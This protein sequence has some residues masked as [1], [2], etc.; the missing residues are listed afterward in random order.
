MSREY[1][2]RPIAG[3]AAVV[4]RDDM[5]LLTRRGNPPGRGNWALPGGVVELGESVRDAVVR[6]VR[7]ECGLIVRP[8][9]VL[10]VFDSITRDDA[11]RVRFHYVL[12][13]FLCTIQSGL[14]STGTD[15]LESKW[16]RLAEL[17][18]LSMNPGT[19]SFIKKVAANHPRS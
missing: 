6:E 14:L 10:T 17:E 1:P 3:V 7:E 15:S 8:E 4:F 11:G 12:I 9:K 5:V 2:P 19:L 13:E 18:D 16:I